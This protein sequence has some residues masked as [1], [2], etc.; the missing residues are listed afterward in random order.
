[1]SYKTGFFG[2]STG[3]TREDPATSGMVFATREE[4]DAY[5]PWKML[6]WWGPEGHVVVEVDAEPNYSFLGGELCRLK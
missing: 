2:G 4:A 3:N 1:M 6:S 5:G